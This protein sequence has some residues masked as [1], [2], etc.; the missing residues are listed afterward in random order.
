MKT[1]YIIDGYMWAYTSFY[2]HV[3]QQLESPAGEPT[4]GT[5]VFFRTLFKLLKKY[6]TRCFFQK[7]DVDPMSSFSIFQQFM[8]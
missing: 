3:V 8:R 1:I 4:T 6:F 2:A 7:F 5:Y